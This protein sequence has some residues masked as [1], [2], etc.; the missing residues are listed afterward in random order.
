MT[1]TLPHQDS[2]SDES[3]VVENDNNNS[4]E[5]IDVTP[6]IIHTQHC[7]TVE[8]DDKWHNVAI[9]LKNE[10]KDKLTKEEKQLIESSSRLEK[11]YSSSLKAVENRFLT[12]L[13]START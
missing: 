5:E 10:K 2:S 12:L 6:Y 3:T 4:I 13:K 9:E 7:V 1:L 11:K 8:E